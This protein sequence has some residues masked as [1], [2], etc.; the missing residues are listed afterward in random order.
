MRA[1]REVAA[2][3][4]MALAVAPVAAALL[5]VLALLLLAR[6]G[7]GGL[8]GDAFAGGELPDI[9]LLDTWFLTTALLGWLAGLWFAL[10]LLRRARARVS[11]SMLRRGRAL[12]IV[13][14]VL[15]ALAPVAYVAMWVIGL[16]TPVGH[17]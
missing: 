16:S 5:A 4:M 11:R 7:A 3:E 6:S 2:V 8:W 17:G 13:A 15:A 12:A 9:A 14:F 1:G 10:W